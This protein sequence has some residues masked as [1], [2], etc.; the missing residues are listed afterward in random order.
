MASIVFYFHV[1]Q[2][3]RIKPYQVF[4][5]GADHQYFETHQN[6]LNNQKILKKV[7]LK[8]YL[9]ANEVLYGLLKRYPEF[10]FS[11]SITGVFLEQIKA[12]LPEVLESFQ[13]LVATG[14]VEIVAETYYHSLA[15]LYSTAEFKRQIDIHVKEVKRL[16]NV[17]PQAFRNTE[18]IYND[19][20]ANL[21]ESWG[22]KTIIAEGVDRYL[23]WRSPN[24]VYRPHGTKKLRLLLKNYRLSDD[25]AFRFSNKGWAGYPLSAEKFAHWVS[26]V[27]GNGHVVNL[28]MDYET[29]GEHQWED[30]G[31]FNFLSHLPQAI[32]AH[33]DNRFDTISEAAYRYDPVDTVSMP[34]I[35]SWADLER[36]LSAWV[37]NPIQH[38]ALM[39]LYELES[40]VITSG[41][42]DLIADWR[43]LTTSD[44]FYYMCTKWFSDGDVH[45]YFSPNHTPYEAFVNF[46]NILHDVRQRVYA[47]NRQPIKSSNKKRTAHA[48]T[49]TASI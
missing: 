6:R 41:Q 11:F 22:Y 32:Y 37:G 14:R 1:H 46:S 16:F 26:A 31:I 9:P 5:I 19:D 27:N 30:T 33:P 36:D 15:S 34:D 38:N 25:I 17:T 28:F 42:L 40:A 2:P 3:F 49:H 7:A 10:K 29:F 48:L 47:S 4:D 39:A 24:F 12:Y 13:R 21:I 23:G 44:H 45:K 35:T 18:L 43:K 20:I 8:C